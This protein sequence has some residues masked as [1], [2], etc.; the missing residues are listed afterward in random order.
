MGAEAVALDLSYLEESPR[1]LGADAPGVFSRSLQSAFTRVSEEAKSGGRL[2]DLLDG[3]R[4]ELEENFSGLTRDVDDY[5]GKALAF[6]NCS[7]LALTMIGKENVIGDIDGGGD[8]S[9]S[10]RFLLANNP[11]AGVDGGDDAKTPVMAG[12]MPPIYPLA[13]RSRG[14][15]V[16]N[17]KPDEDGIQR[18]VN[19]LFRYKGEYFPHLSIAA[20]SA[21]GKAGAVNAGTEAIAVNDKAVTSGGTRIPR[22]EDGAVLI[23]WPKKSFYDYNLMSL[24]GLVQHVRVEAVFAENL[25]R[26]S[27]DG[28]FS[29]WDGGQTPWE[30]YEAA[31]SVK[32]AIME[33]DDFYAVQDW[34]TL[35][36]DFFDSIHVFLTGGYEEAILESVAGDGETSAYVADMFRN[37]RGQEERLEA[38]RKEAAVLEGGFCVIGA[39]ATSMTDYGTNPYEENF[40]NVGTYAAVVNMILSGD[41]IDDSPAW[42]SALAALALALLMGFLVNRLETA[43]SIVS[44]I[45]LL[46]AVSGFF[47]AFFVITRVYVGFAMPLVSSSLTF[48]TLMV[49]KFLSANRDRAFLHSAF[50][51]YLA[52]QVIDE[53]IADPSKLNLGGEKREMTAIFTD[54]QGFSGISEKLDPAAL[55][56]LLN[57][58]LTAMSNIVMDN[59]GTID[60]YEGDAIIAFFGAPIPREN[61][62]A[63]ACRSALAIKETEAELNRAILAEGLSPVPIFTRIGINTGEMVVGNMGAENKMDY[64]VMGNAV[65]LASRLEGVNKQYQTGGILLS[66][67]T[68]AQIGGEFLCRRLDRVRVVG[69]NTPLRLYE[70]TGLRDELSDMAGSTPEAAAVMQWNEAMDLLE[71]G[72]YWKALDAFTAY[73]KAHPA[74][75][76]AKMYAARCE[77]YSGAPPRGGWDNVYNLTE[78]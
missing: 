72:D 43:A 60:K 9:D 62:A 13:S 16:V 65:N 30:L 46:A 77:K 48:V 73:S 17:N 39:D 78:K 55:V 61:H 6:S 3:A 11:F 32:A 19:L 36:A 74:D 68:H 2:D 8:I 69:V 34:K 12:L 76:T 51:R 5:F 64:T 25:R 66:E 57:R 31:E 50:S 52:P 21:W 10:E 45:V 75:G 53:L 67:Y 22:A 59:L 41:F 27:D 56:A 38:I 18:R 42:V 14:V 26:M 54:I 23:K 44:G 49:V 33:G 40:P 47:I 4:S 58:Y 29:V 7:F 63:L 24:V 71:S 28:F 20:L 35:R 15:G 1:R 37:A 70:L